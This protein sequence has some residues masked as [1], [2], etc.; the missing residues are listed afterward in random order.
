MKQ[1]KSICISCNKGN[2]SFYP[3]LLPVIY[4]IFRFCKEQFINTYDQDNWKIL[5]YNL[6]YLFYL[7]LP[8][9]FAIIFIPI[10]KSKSEGDSHELNVST[11]QYHIA[12]VKTKKKRMF[13]LIYII[14]L[15]E[16]IQENGDLLV[17]YW[18]RV[19]YTQWLVEKK[20]GLIFFVPLISYFILKNDLFKHH[21]LALILGLI[22]AFII[23]F[24]RFPLE[25]STLDDYPFHL[26]Y[27]LFSIILSFAFVLI[28]YVMI[29]FVMISPYLFLFYNGI[30][31]ILNSFICILLEYF[32]VVN[33][34]VPD[35]YKE[36]DSNYFYNNYV[37]IFTCFIGKGKEFYIYLCLM[38]I[39][40]FVYYTLSI[41]T[42]Y[43]FNLYLIIIVET[44]IPI[45]TDMIEIF[46]KEEEKIF[47]NK[48][49][50]ARS[51]YQLIGY[52]IIL[53]AA[54][55]LNEII[56][57]NCFGFNKNIRSN[58]S[59]RSV[60]DVEGSFTL[61]QDSKGTTENESDSDSEN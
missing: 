50:L 6:P 61:R 45:D 16:V 22:G 34:P 3:I 27:I 12:A 26:L 38:L 42:I 11:K 17:Y 19:G 49:I 41:L 56:I 39:L 47:N 46:Y 4:M 28:K 55:I 1:S 10:I 35:E 48:K 51:L 14:S 52:I 15:L 57:L 43:N 59:T 30:F 29:K 44:C 18:G 40:L 20:S 53:I 2:I 54:L 37:E 24:C 33:L 23:N 8:K 60:L 32:L 13:L 21:I 25:F 36:N 58:I 7:Y 31:N 9:I 5:K